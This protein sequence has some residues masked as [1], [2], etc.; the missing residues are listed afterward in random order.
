LRETAAMAFVGSND[1][2]AKF[3]RFNFFEKSDGLSHRTALDR[4]DMLAT[5]LLYDHFAGSGYR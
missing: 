5:L 3:G 2:T 1:F 4:L